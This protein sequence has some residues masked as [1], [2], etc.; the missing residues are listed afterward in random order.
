MP[1]H[2]GNV[3]AEVTNLEHTVV[4]NVPAKKV[5]IVDNAGNQFLGGGFNIPTYDSFVVQ[6]P[7]TTKE[8]YIFKVDTVEVARVTI[9]YTDTTKN[10]LLSAAMS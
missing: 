3:V 6:T 1:Q 7:T 8:I 9:N 4:N 10:T 2:T 5:V